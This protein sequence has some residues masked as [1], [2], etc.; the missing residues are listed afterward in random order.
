M[1]GGCLLC[2]LY[3]LL[4]KKSINKA[5]KMKPEQFGVLITSLVVSVLRKWLKVIFKKSFNTYINKLF[6]HRK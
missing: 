2:P 3:L 6:T 5:Y 1:Y 4:I